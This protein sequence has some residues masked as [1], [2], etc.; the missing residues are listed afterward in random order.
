MV[1]NFIISNRSSRRCKNLIGIFLVSPKLPQILQVARIF[2]WIH[3]FK[4]AFIETQLTVANSCQY[5]IFLID[6]LYKKI[7]FWLTT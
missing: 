6:K 2:I 4:V 1:L 3:L 5:S 7:C